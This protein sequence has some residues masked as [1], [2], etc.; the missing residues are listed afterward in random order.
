MHGP[1]NAKP[2]I[3]WEDSTPVRWHLA[4]SEDS[5]VDI[6]THIMRAIIQER[7]CEALWHVFYMVLNPDFN[8]NLLRL[9]VRFFTLY[10]YYCYILFRG[11]RNCDSR[12]VLE[13][14]WKKRYICEY[15]EIWNLI[16]Q[17]M[18]IKTCFCIGYGINLLKATGYLILQQVQHKKIVHSAHSVFIG[19]VSIS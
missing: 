14:F 12:C 2:L 15:S 19:C 8:E 3:T 16:E 10:V 17:K 13:I 18:Y 5:V 9:S 6:D 4:F 11:R 7:C 1:R